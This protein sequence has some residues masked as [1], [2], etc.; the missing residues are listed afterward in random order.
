MYR[1]D[2]WT[3]Q[4]TPG[5]LNVTRQTVFFKSNLPTKLM[6]FIGELM[7]LHRIVIIL[8]GAFVNIIDNG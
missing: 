1:G 5:V 8:I 6:C 3:D 4:A 7:F 2:C